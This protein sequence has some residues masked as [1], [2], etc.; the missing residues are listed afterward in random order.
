MLRDQRA[1]L[2]RGVRSRP[3]AEGPHPG[4]EPV[5]QGVGHV[6]DHD[7]HRDGHAAR[8][9]RPVG[10]ADQGVGRGVEICVGHHHQVVLRA[11]ERL[12]PLSGRARRPVDPLRHRGG[13]NEAHRR[14]LGMVE[15]RIHRLAVAVHHVEH[16]LGT[17]RLREQARHLEARRRI[18]LGR[19]EDE[20]VPARD[21]HGPHPH[22]DHHREVEGSDAG[23]DAEW[24][25]Q[26]PGVDAA[27]HLLGHL[28][29]EELGNAAGELHHLHAASQLPAGVGEDL[30]VLGG[31]EP[32]EHVGAGLGQLAEPEQ[33]P[34]ANHRRSPRPCGERGG[35]GAHRGVHVGRG[36]ER[37]L[38][39][40]RAGGRVE[41]VAGPAPLTGDGPPADPVRQPGPGRRRHRLLS[42]H[43][44]L[45]RAMASSP[46]EACRPSR[47]ASRASPG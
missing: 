47:G 27:A 8:A 16:A 9:G 21:G 35:G 44:R 41:H 32:G 37:N 23:H 26:G 18:A 33:D 11:A 46:G 43:V 36:G 13:A 6:A 15:Q 28:A 34:G 17:A 25:T 39:G 22:R 38:P 20:R 42:A 24:L 3:H 45:R 10:G 1:H 5:D 14:Q 31:D 12:H 30:P 2:H 4:R 29:L 40:A 19:L 7:R